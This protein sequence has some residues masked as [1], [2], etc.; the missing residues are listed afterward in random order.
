[1]TDKPMTDEKPASTNAIDRWVK[2]HEAENGHYAALAG[3]ESDL[4]AHGDAIADA[5]DNMDVYTQ[6]ELFS[7]VCKLIEEGER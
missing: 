7:F 3:F 2:T 5:Y 6:I 4:R 1:M